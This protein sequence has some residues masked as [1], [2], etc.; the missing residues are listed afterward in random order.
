MTRTTR[1]G[2]SA[3]RRLVL[4]PLVL[5]SGSALLGA[6]CEPGLVLS[7]TPADGSTVATFSFP[8]VIELSAA[9]DPA[10]LAVV[11]NG[12]DVTAQ[13]SGGPTVFTAN[14]AAGAPLQDQNRLLVTVHQA[15]GALVTSRPVDF[16]YLP[17]KAR[18]FEISDSADCPTGPI[19]HCTV[20]DYLLGNETARFVVQK[21]GQRDMGFV[22][23]YGGNL[24]DAELV[25]NG[26]RQ[27]RDNFLEVQ[28]SINIESVVNA[29][30]ADVVNDGQDGTTAIVRTCGPDDLLDDINPSSVIAQAGG[31]L[32][33]GVD[34]VDNDVW[35]C[36]E[37]RL[38]PQQ[39]TV[40]VVT[41]VENLSPANLPLFVGDY[42]NGGGELEQFTPLSTSAPVPLAQAG[43]G[44]MFANWGVQAIAFFGYGE[45]EGVDYALVA[46][47]PPQ[48]PAPSSTFTQAGVSFVLHGNSV[49]LVLG[50]GV[51]SNF[52]VPAGGTNSFRRWFTVGD[53][54][55]ANAVQAF[56]D[57]HALPTGTLRGCVTD[58]SG[59]PLAGARI[60]AGRDSSGGTT[61]LRVLRGHW[62]AG[63]DGCYEGRIPTGSYLVAAA[64]EGYPYEGGGSTAATHL[65]DI[66]AG[67]TVVQDV[68][69]PETGALRVEVVDHDGNPIPARI[70]V[71]GF[72][73][74]PEPTLLATVL[75]ANDTRTNLFYDLTVDGLPAGISRT[76]Y[77]EA[78]GTLEFALEPGSYQ[79]AVSRGGEWSLDTELVTIT[80]SVTTTVNAQLAHVLDTTGWISAD[81]HVH[82]IDSP[83]SRVS[84]SD[85]IRSYA[86]EGVDAII[87]TDHAY[88]ADLDGQI[89]AM[90]FTDFVDATPGEEITTF[91]YGHFNA[92][93][94]RP[95]PSRIQTQGSTDHAGA[96]PPGQDFPSLGHFTLT[97]AQI[98]AAVMSDPDNAG[99]DTVVQVNHIDSHF[100]PLKIDTAATPPRSF[101]GP[102]EPQI[103]RLDPSVT[104]FFHHFPALELWN[105]DS[106]NKQVVE[107]FGERIGIWMNLLNQGLLATFIAD[108][109]THQYHDL[110]SAG[111]RT[112]TPSSS[113]A[114]AAISDN[115][116][117][118]AVRAG[119]AVGGQ[120]L[121]VTARLV[122]TDGSGGVAQLAGVVPSGTQPGTAAAGTLVSVANGEVNLEIRV[123]APTWAPYDRIVLYRNATTTVAQ[124][125]DGIPTLY[126]AQASQ[127]LTA[128][129]DFP[130]ATVP[131][132]GSSRF[133][134]NL[135][136]PLTGLSADEWIVVAARG[137]EGVSPPMFPVYPNPTDVTTENPDLAAL[138]NVT[139]TE[140]GVR[141]LGVTNALYV[142]VDGN[143]VFDAPG[144][145]VAP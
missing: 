139:A 63:A 118:R 68:V 59:D 93:P 69:L 145:S 12:D 100:D 29:Q 129:V 96:A 144:P 127:T 54:S 101:L 86:G 71:V 37:Y 74:S 36:T 64:K 110:A 81:Y 132:N 76:E 14:L 3:L 2:L 113:D 108:T 77:T 35:A 120:G 82:M 123:Q 50:L 70:A 51:P 53:G 117:G 7:V 13:F 6:N 17:P 102:G 114:V 135:V 116:I 38:D 138:T 111:A 9:A 87:A 1:V 21:P 4:L 84:R 78:N 140:K 5:G 103:F 131:V 27:G 19:A 30:T 46:A 49:P 85:R 16:E 22:A 122:A 98:E 79:V 72:D 43:V 33:A 126:G 24:I 125:N 55:A 97:P 65:V 130:V 48:V 41:T 10:T 15:A 26:V 66:T 39:R 89:A 142:D 58:A 95:D 32:P 57:V 94:Q 31:Q 141:A 88:V 121:F 56:A 109:D 137:T 62:V 115:E 99:L 107:F 105:G 90:G 92:Y 91:D 42:I 106:H 143:G 61:A 80:A 11:L 112:W 18:A 124:S 8:V 45:A 75:S 136:V 119:K 67:G 40:E 83:D 25:E 34:D 28:P 133:E 47:S 44:E 52:S 20:G 134:T 23:T 73:P 60:A 104:N 128:G